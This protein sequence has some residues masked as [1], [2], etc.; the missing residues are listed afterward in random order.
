MEPEK[1]LVRCFDCGIVLFANMFD[2]RSL[3]H[4]REVIGYDYDG[5]G[6]TPSARRSN[7]DS[8]SCGMG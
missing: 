4:P 7:S 2:G 6:T 5:G 3:R 1:I 8:S